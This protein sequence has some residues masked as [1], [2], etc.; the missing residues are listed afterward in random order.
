M[1]L[2]GL[3]SILFC[4]ALLSACGNDA[5]PPAEA[6]PSLPAITAVALGELLVH[7]ERNAPAA[8][9]G[10]HEAR[11]S[12]ELAAT[13]QA[14]PVAVGESVAA[15]G[16]LVRLDPRDAELALERAEAALAQAEAR[17]AQA[18][19]QLKR[20]QALRERNF[21]SPE[22]LT[23]R[24]TE[25]LAVQADVRAARAARDTARRVLEKHSLRAPF[26]GVVRERPAQLGELAAPGNVLLTLVAAGAPELAVQLQPQ[27]AEAVQQA[28]AWHFEA[29]G[30]RHEVRLIRVSPTMH[31][32]SRSV[33]ARFAFVADAP[34]I[35]TEGRLLWR[36]ARAWLPADLLVR[37][38]AQYGVF[39]VADGVARFHVLPGAS[40]GRPALIDLPSETRI[41]VQGRHALQDGVALP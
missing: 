2:S 36:E 30:S 32:A 3:S 40:D 24:E 31:R 38:N 29:L 37:R 7:P 18:E 35:G 13:I 8:V 4:T 41:V 23:L 28:S 9:I 39:T 25:Q 20:A 26:A 15:G 34:A 22:A 33:E 14:L 17:L 11:I 1:R 16:L 19:A 21:Y 6:A 12:A 27:D 5:P 10:R